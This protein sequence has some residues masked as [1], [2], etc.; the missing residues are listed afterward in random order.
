MPQHWL[1]ILGC[2]AI[3]FLLPAA[4]GTR[5]REACDC[6]G[7]SRQCIF[8]IE[9]L[10]RTGNGYRC[11]NCIDNTEGNNCERCKEGF[12][13]QRHQ[14]GCVA[15]GCNPTGSTSVQCD[16][17]GQCHCKPGV[18]GNKCDRCQDNFHSFSEAGCTAA[19]QKQI[20]W[21]NCNP[22]GSTRKCHSG[23]CVCKAATTGDQCQSCKQGYYYLDAGNPEGCSPCFCSGHSTKCSSAENYSVHK[24]T[25]TFQ[26][27]DDGWQAQGRESPLQLQWSSHHKEIY[28]AARSSNPIYFV[29]PA[30]FLGNQQL[31]Y[32][33]TLSF[34]YRVNRP[35]RHPSQQDVVLEGA[36]LKVTAPFTPNGR[37][38]PC[39]SGKMYTLRL[40]EHP[41]SNWSPRLSRAEYHRLIGN[42]TALQIRATY[43]D[44]TG[45]LSNVVLVSAQPTPGTPALWVEECVCPA[46]YHGQFCEKCAPGYKRE[47]SAQLGAL[48]NCVLCNCQGGGLC[49]PETGDCYSGDETMRPVQ[50]ACPNGFYSFPRNPQ[51]CQPCPCPSGFGCSV[52]PSTE[53]VVCNKCLPGTEG[54]RCEVCTYGYF[55]DP[56]GEKGPARPCQPCQCKDTDPNASWICNRLTGECHCK[57]GYFR[58]PLSLNP[59]EK[60][61]ACNCNSVGAEPLRCQSD[62]SC[63]CK[64]GFEGRSCEHT[65]CPDC[66]SQ[67]KNQVDQYLQQLRGLEMLLHQIDSGGKPE[68]NAELE[69]KLQEAKEMLQ[70][71]LREAQSLQASDRALASRLSKMKVQEFSYQSRLDEIDET[72]NRLQSLGGRYQTQ[73]QDARRLVERA[74]VDLEQSQGKLGGMIIPS[75]DIPGS[76]NS[77]LILAQEAMTLANR[78]TQLAN[79][80]EQAARAAEDASEQAL[81]LLQSSANG[82]GSLANSMQGLQKKYGEIK[83]LSTDLEADAGRLMADADKTYQGS[84]LLIGFLARLPKVDIA[85]FQE[86]ANQLRQ[87]ADSLT[88]LVDVYMTQYQ[89]LQSNTRNW[90]AEMK[91]LL[92]K[93]ENDRLASVQLLSRANVAKSMADRALNAGNATLDEVDNILKN[94][95]EFDLEVGN[96]QL[97]ATEAMQRLPVISNTV[98]S[99]TEKTRRAESA[100]GAAVTEAE[101]ARRMAGEAK[102]IAGGINQEIGRLTLE[103]NRTADG[104][105]ALEREIMALRNEAR[106]TDARLQRK[107]LEIDTDA[108]AAQEVV[109]MSQRAKAN[110][111]RAGSSAQEVLSALEDILRMMDQPEG[112]DEESVNMLEANLR[113]ARTSNSQL[114]EQLLQ[115]EQTAS[116][117]KLRIQTLKRSITEIL[118]DIKN[119]EE[120]R[121]NLPPKCYNVQPIERP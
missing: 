1:A 31:S 112:M 90:E 89:R 45:Y 32:G 102:E 55:G 97:K 37:T 76:S 33:Q 47:D 53:E 106:E 16:N 105:L 111:G 24:I 119:L 38:L 30:K 44:S 70:Q 68:G 114:K 101:A 56:L 94:L 110:A 26:Q 13:R 41:S 88:S 92:L 116:Q 66:Y 15:C 113:K 63:I 62:G 96:K 36:G 72:T 27:D 10:R 115:L 4:A 75:P 48:G 17:R 60:C 29:A 40:D 99:A 12:Y 71:F 121:Q 46:G 118:A 3:S 65:R 93:G 100:L 2:L 5:K 6:N 117:Q 83:L 14:N 59:A 109:Q 80:I 35:G 67:V 98:A 43:G 103:A 18:T 108:T 107:A 23:R 77:F 64:P 57:E 91:E 120:I 74:R 52:L 58:N 28:V 85:L 51:N 21:C 82:R 87:K 73:V 11:L 78:H 84:Q 95:R 69:R 19:G 81:A 49:D 42:L 104:V 8:D 9:L 22:A 34:H 39:R 86:E 54:T 25:S 20:S 50:A 79:T 61:Q 7:K